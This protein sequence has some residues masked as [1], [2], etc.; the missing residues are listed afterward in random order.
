MKKSKIEIQTPLEFV[1]HKIKARCGRDRI[2]GIFH[3]KY[4]SASFTEFKALYEQACFH[5]DAERL[6]RYKVNKG[7]ALHLAAQLK[8]LKDIANDKQLQVNITN[9]VNECGV[10]CVI[11]CAKSIKALKPFVLATGVGATSVMDAAKR[12][13]QCNNEQRMEL[14]KKL[15]KRYDLMPTLDEKFIIFKNKDFLYEGTLI[16]CLD[17]MNIENYREFR[18]INDLKSISSKTE[19]ITK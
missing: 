2:A 3:K 7:H 6:E 19:K 11:L 13:T 18:N 9:K 10:P 15:L 4:P 1:I 17:V 16:E 14:K 8:E 5:R 12:A